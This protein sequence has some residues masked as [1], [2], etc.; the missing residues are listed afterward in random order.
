MHAW[1]EIRFH[2]AQHAVGRVWE[3]PEDG[4][5]A[6]H[7]QLGFAADLRGGGDHVLEFVAAHLSS[8]DLLEDAPPLR[9]RQETR[10]RR[11]LPQ[12]AGMRIV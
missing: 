7:D 12:I 2:R 9:L 11:V 3:R 10:E 4:L 6:D 5:A 1:I 8:A